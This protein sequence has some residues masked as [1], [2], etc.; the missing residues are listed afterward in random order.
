MTK[1]LPEV[2]RPR[3]TRLP[4]TLGWRLCVALTLAVGC[5]TGNSEGIGTDGSGGDQGSTGGRGD[6]GSGGTMNGSGGEFTSTP[7]TGGLGAGGLG[8][9]G[10]GTG[11]ANATGGAGGTTEGGGGSGTGGAGTGGAS[12]PVTVDNPIVSVE[13]ED[14][15][16][17][18]IMVYGGKYY[19][20]PTTCPTRD[21]LSTY[22]K[23]Y[24]SEDLQTWVDRGIILDA[25]DV[26]WGSTQS[27]APAIQEKD[28]T[29]YFYFCMNQ[30]IGVATSSSPTGPFVDALGHPLVEGHIDPDVFIDDDGQA[31]LYYG[32]HTPRVRK[33]APDM[34]SFAGEEV[35]LPTAN[36][37]EGVYVFKRNEVYY[38][39]GSEN[40]A[41]DAA[42]QV[43]YSMGTSPLGPFTKQ[44]VILQ[45]SGAFVGTGHNSVLRLPGTDEWLT[46]YHRHF[47]PD[48]G[49]QYREICMESM[50]FND[51]GTIAPVVPGPTFTL[52]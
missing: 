19:I 9:G 47:V 37:R 10:F 5:S 26:S 32:Q 18:E 27:W 17:P 34:V 50:T 21:W 44:E 46:A 42:Y 3:T 52:H 1:R 12:G 25:K 16:D 23:V 30:N 48:G 45:Q 20:Y 33:L 22:F 15:A 24:E 40:D 28:G 14:N 11:G 4:W 2:D 38:M 29:F 39:M 31:Y 51:D 49:G 13:Q 36:F 7:G 43:S 41:R 8:T 6:I 35:A